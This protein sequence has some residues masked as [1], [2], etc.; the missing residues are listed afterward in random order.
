MSNGKL[1]GELPIEDKQT[2]LHTCLT[3]CSA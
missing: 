1:F 2:G 3:S